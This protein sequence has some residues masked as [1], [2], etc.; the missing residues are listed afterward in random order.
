MKQLTGFL[1]FIIVVFILS[2][3]SSGTDGEF[4]TD[5][6]LNEG[7]VIRIEITG[8]YKNTEWLVGQKYKAAALDTETTMQLSLVGYD[9][10]GNSNSTLTATWS[11]S[12]QKVAIVDNTGKITAI[13]AGEAEVTVKLMS[14]ITEEIISDTIV[15]TVL[16][17][18]VTGK[19]WTVTTTYSLPQ[20]IWDHASAIWNSHI[21]VAGGHSSCT[22][23]SYKDCG[24][25]D[26]VYYAPINKT[27]GSIGKFIQTAIL[28]SYIRGHALLAYNGYLYIIGGIEQPTFPEPPYPDPANFETILNEKVYYARVNTDGSLGKWEQTA[29][30]PPPEVRDPPIAAD[31]AGLFALSATVHTISKDGKD[32][33]YIYVTGGWSA[34]L[35]KNVKTVLVGPINEVDRPDASPGSIEKWIH[36]DL[37]DLPDDYGLSKHTSVAASVNGNNYIYVI[38]GN[39]GNYGSQIFHNEILYAK[40]AEDGILTETEQDGI[41][42]TWHYASASLHE[43]LIDHASVSIG[44]YIFVLGGRNGVE[45]SNDEEEYKKF[46]EVVYF[47]IDDT[48][49]LQSLQR[50]VDLPEPLFHHAAVAD[51]NIAADPI[52]FY[53][54]GGAG[55]NTADPDN[56][57]NTVHH[58]RS[59]Q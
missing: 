21:Y 26:K 51:I 28:P 42:S 30:L 19:Q 38:G 1:I 20:A 29:S 52:N 23:V 22:P 54:T 45:G 56:R 11:S 36:N 53:L 16:P 12:D 37:S 49:D 31:K 47:Y 43:K 2:G 3:C 15:I 50:S 57:K 24:F 58:F 18:P 33:G 13:S 44:R 25:T 32:K 40:V 48:G 5:Y 39:S 27:D 6:G 9:V 4:F 46:K 35:K 34:E 55:G 7:D 17:S 14:S 59:T 8:A 10:E 41:L